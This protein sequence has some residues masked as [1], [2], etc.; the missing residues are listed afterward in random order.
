M[1]VAAPIKRPYLWDLSPSASAVRYCLRRLRVYL[2]EWVPNSDRNDGLDE[3]MQAISECVAQVSDQHQN[4]KPF[5][6]GHSLGGTLAAIFAALTPESIRALVLLG[7]PL[8]FQPATSQFRD[9][10]VSMVP[11]ALPD[12]EP[13]PGSLLSS[14]SALAS[15]ATF[16]WSRLLDAALTSTDRWAVDVHARVERWAL[17]EVRL[18][19]KLVHEIIDWLYRDNRLCRGVLPIGGRFV[20]PSNVSVATLAVVNTDDEIAPLASVAPFIE[21]MPTSDARIIQFPGEL[22]V[23]L[24]HL[25]ILVGR[26]S[27][28]QVWPQIIAWLD[29]H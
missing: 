1:I 17:D 22:G 24:Q 27:F 18:P 23:C 12:E 4:S 21:A 29:A 19:G 28:M 3:Y 6:I 26:R 9:A 13:F 8:C 11:S 14:M 2:L 5:L 16:V 7:A 15:P 25:A 10:L 20:G